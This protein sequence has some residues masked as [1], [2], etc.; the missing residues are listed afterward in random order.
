MAGGSGSLTVTVDPGGSYDIAVAGISW[1]FHGNVGYPLSNILVGSGSDGL[2]AY[3]EIGFDFPSDTGSQPATTRHAAIRSYS[4]HPDVLFTVSNAAAAAN[5]FKF[6]NFSQYP[7]NLDHLTFSGIF[8][9]P[10]F[11]DFSNESPWVFFDSS[12]NTFIL[13]PATN[14]MAAS[15]A[16]GPN[17]ELA[18]G[19]APAISSL[20]QGFE[21]RTLL[22]IQQGINRAFDGWGQ[23][24][25]ALHGKTRPASDADASLSKVGYWTDNGATYYYHTADSLSYEQTLTAVKGDFDRLGIGLGSLQLDS[26][27][28][29]KGAGA[30]WSDNG[31]G[32][33]EYVAAAPPFDGGLSKFQQSL[34]IPLI[35]HARWI[36]ANSPY[37]TQYKMSGN[38]VLDPAYWNYVAGYLATSGVATYEQDWL[39]DKAQPDFNL[40]DAETFLDN[41]AA[42]MAQRKLTLQYCMASPRHFMQSSKYSNLTTIRT[43][44]DRLGRDRWTEFLYTSRFASALGVWPFTDNFMSTETNNLLVAALSA[45]PLGL[46]DPIGALNG[47]NLLHAVRQDGVIVKP[48]VP[49]TPA[50]SSYANMAHSVDTPQIATTYSDFGAL[51]TNYWFAYAQGTNTQITFRPA[52]LGVNQ[53]AYF[54]DYFSGSGQV[55]NPLDVLAR[56]I[57]GDALYLVVAP[58]GPSEMAVVGDVDQFVTMGKK[59]IP[60]VTDDGEIH[61][62]VAFAD[63]EMVRTIKGY[64]PFPPAAKATAGR[65]GKVAYSAVSQQFQIPVMPG[66]DGTAGIRIHRARAKTSQIGAPSIIVV[67]GTGSK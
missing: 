62:T 63:G 4:D 20:P 50:D 42:A 46:A 3:L 58:I 22:V 65:V 45:G 7:Q 17:K 49:L 64:S 51:R 48:D 43:S 27:F 61:L 37:R 31:S 11:S 12:F 29:P 28:Y 44:A 59:R 8:A 14:F 40:T 19:I 35:T 24:L 15:T 32:I 18:S 36:D 26:W 55:V 34:G 33:Y 56:P 57:A 67:G 10:T 66:P 41:M 6:P 38:V 47:A 39:D 5:T 2:G 16:W 53:P 13:S 25:T 52:D 21:H 9:P 30:S 23:A 60:A 54:Y 1:H